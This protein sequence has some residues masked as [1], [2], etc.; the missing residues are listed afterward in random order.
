MK[1]AVSLEKKEP[2][3]SMS[4][5]LIS[6]DLILSL[7]RDIIRITGRNITD[8][9]KGIEYFRNRNPRIHVID[10]PF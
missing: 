4:T 10:T 8:L 5:F 3:A 1:C 6:D 7:S 2:L 9:E